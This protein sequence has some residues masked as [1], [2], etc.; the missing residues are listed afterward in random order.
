M[1]PGMSAESQKEGFLELSKLPQ[2]VMVS[3]RFDPLNAVRPDTPI[4]TLVK[5]V[6]SQ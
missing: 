6:S 1:L 3:R 2:K 5:A 4:R